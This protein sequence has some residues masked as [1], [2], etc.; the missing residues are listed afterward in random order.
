VD[1][2][3]FI[4]RAAG[5]TRLYRL[6]DYREVDSAEMQTPYDTALALKSDIP[7]VPVF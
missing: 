4:V 6:R 7:K 5:G 3:L 1:R 2:G